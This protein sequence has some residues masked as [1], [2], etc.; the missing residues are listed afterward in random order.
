MKMASQRARKYTPML[1]CL[2]LL[3]LTGC[4]SAE[5]HSEQK[6]A[7]ESASVRS[8]SEVSMQSEATEEPTQS[9]TTENE[10]SD[11]LQALIAAAEQGQPGKPDTFT[12]E[13]GVLYYNGVEVNEER[14]SF[15]LRESDISDYG[16]L[17]NYNWAEDLLIEDENLVDLDFLKDC[18]QLKSLTLNC[19]ASDFQVI[20]T[21]PQ[22][23]FLDIC[24][25]NLTDLDFLSGLSLD[26]LNCSYCAKLQD[27]T[28]LDGM[29]SMTFL[30][31]FQCGGVEDFSALQSLSGLV[32]LSLS[33]TKFAD[34]TLLSSLPNLSVLS[35][36][37][38]EVD[39]KA[40]ADAAY[41]LTRLSSDADEKTEAWLKEIFPNC[42]FT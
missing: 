31:L 6:S 38:C 17:K 24:S 25:P 1:L 28:G 42:E 30:G 7:S 40:F 8:V 39:Y 37:G 26:F 2:S 11:S 23:L 27:I 36:E 32:Q 13:D 21:L 34:L 4:Q 33:G 9:E 5:V 35:I 20:G 10:E 15:D 19:G 22:L 16:F 18:T 14:K 12:V 29:S 41:S 3:L